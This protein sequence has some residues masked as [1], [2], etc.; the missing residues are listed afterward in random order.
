VE[1]YGR[2][3]VVDSTFESAV[4]VRLATAIHAV[5]SALNVAKWRRIDL[6]IAAE[7]SGD[8]HRLVVKP[9]VHWRPFANASAVHQR[10]ARMENHV[11][12]FN[13]P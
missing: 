13:E 9:S 4:G 6:L 11:G 5:Y 1:R 10:I 3:V 8:P 2:R 7:W 12:A